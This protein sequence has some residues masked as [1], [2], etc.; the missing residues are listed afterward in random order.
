MSEPSGPRHSGDTRWRAAAMPM[1]PAVLPPGSPTDDSCAQPLVQQAQDPLVPN[2]VLEKL[3]QPDV[4]EPVEKAANIRVE[5]PVHPLPF[6]PGR[7]RIQR[8]VLAAPRP[9][10]VGKAQEVLLVDGV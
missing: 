4:I 5:H 2:P 3:L 8:I 7:Q 6:D 10:P 1:P 9:E